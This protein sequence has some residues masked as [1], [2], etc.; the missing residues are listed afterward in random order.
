MNLW[1]PDA[2]FP[3]TASRQ[4]SPLASALQIQP[5]SGQGEA[6]APQ[7]NVRARR[8]AVPRD[9]AGPSFQ[10]QPRNKRISQCQEKFDRVALRDPRGPAGSEP[11]TKA[12]QISASQGFLVL[13]LCFPPPRNNGMQG[14][15]VDQGTRLLSG[16]Q[17]GPRGGVR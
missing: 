5:E 3:V 10:P 13:P 9:S 4:P 7:Q 15:Y 12:A 1:G 17:G 8:G 14:V 16:T 11:G 2:V 6:L